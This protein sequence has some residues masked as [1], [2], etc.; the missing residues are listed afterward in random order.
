MGS[1]EGRVE[2]H[3]AQGGFGDAVSVF[4]DP[5]ALTIP[6]PDPHEARFVTLA[7]DAFGRVLVVVWTQ[8]GEDIRVIS[9]RKA[10]RREQR[11]Y[12]EG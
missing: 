5:R 12:D 4:D 1:P 7:T 10:T 2:S 11:Q 8:R 6:D 3:Q 9:A